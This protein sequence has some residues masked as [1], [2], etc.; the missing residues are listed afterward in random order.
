MKPLH[1][2]LLFLLILSINSLQ[3]QISEG[4]IPPSIQ[5][6][7][8]TTQVP[9]QKMPAFDQKKAIEEAEQDRQEGFNPIVGKLF[10]VDFNTQN[11]GI[12]ETLPNGDKVWRLAI[13]S[14]R[15]LGL[16][17]YFDKYIL[18]QGAKL[19]AYNKDRTQILGAFT[20]RN[21]KVY[22]KLTLAFVFDETLIIEYYEPK[23]VTGQGVLQIG[24]IGHLFSDTFE[25]DS[26]NDTQEID[27]QYGSSSFCNVDI[28][29]PEGNDW[30][31][32]KRAVCRFFFPT[33]NGAFSGCTGALV[34]N[35]TND[36]TPY[37]LTANHCLNTN[38]AAQGAIFY[39]N[40]ESPSCNGPDGS[41][42]QTISGATL[43]A[44]GTP[45]DFTLLE[46]SS[47]PPAS[48]NAYLAG[49]DKSGNWTP[50]VTGIHHPSLDVKKISSRANGFGNYN[51]EVW[52]VF[53]WDFGVVEGGSSGSPLFDA[54]KRIVGQAW[55]TS[56]LSDTKHYVCNCS[57]WPNPQ[58]TGYG[59]FNV[60]WWGGGSSGNSLRFWLD[61]NNTGSNTVNGM[62]FPSCPLAGTPCNDNNV[63]TINDVEDGNCNCNGS[64]PPAGIACDDGNAVTINDQQD[65]NCNCSGV[66]PPVGT[67][68]DD[69]NAN[70][71]NDIADGSC[72]CFG[73]SCIDSLF[74]DDTFIA[75][76]N[77][78]Y[79]AGSKIVS[80]STIEPTA[81]VTYNAGQQVRLTT[82]FHA[83]NGCYFR[84]YIEGCNNNINAT[85][86]CAPFLDLSGNI[87]SGNYEAL[88][89][90][91]TSGKLD[92][93]NFV[94]IQAGNYIECMDSL[95][96]PKGSELLLI[97]EDCEEN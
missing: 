30:Q 8:T 31:T 77:Q 54:N 56:C 70:T 89:H 15:A 19:F 74:I 13:Q 65:G 63:A 44:T 32:E 84:G 11:S 96:V 71:S 53:D 87:P 58:T 59:K 17:V 72:N 21:N 66:C 93:N 88:S 23:N 94:R 47:D 5:K 28:N 67:P 52:G 82:G 39:F 9:L 41:T 55:F 29:C 10:S 1:I 81:Y 61:P 20:N 38:A 91:N 3:A 95:Y 2:A 46:L 83:R 79:E 51:N 48:Y 40:Y 26:P 7:W 45:T 43:K 42:A 85:I 80:I 75:G 22:E 35:T 78:G 12:W 4:G 24:K 27:A 97:I 6:N 18:P 16:N 86:T 64:C 34:N 60:S 37:F 73:S 90:I 36:G 76:N 25:D 69:G 33:N 57:G 92:S 14:D 50:V 62:E 68:C 49:W